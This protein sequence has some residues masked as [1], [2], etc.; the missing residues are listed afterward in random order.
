MNSKR[1]KWTL[2]AQLFSHIKLDLARSVNFV[3]LLPFMGE[4]GI[5][6]DNIKVDCILYSQLFSYMKVDIVRSALYVY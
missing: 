1:L 5:H 2:S 3:Y 4:I 6:R